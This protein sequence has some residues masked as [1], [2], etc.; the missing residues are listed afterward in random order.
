MLGLSL[1]GIHNNDMMKMTDFTGGE[2]NKEREEREQ[3][4]LRSKK[5]NFKGKEVFFISLHKLK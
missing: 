3:G 1:R 2:E 4:E 5:Y